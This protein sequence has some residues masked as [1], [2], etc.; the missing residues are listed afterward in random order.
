MLRF[1]NFLNVLQ[2][3]LWFILLAG[4]V[5]MFYVKYR[6]YTVSSSIS[7]LDKKIESLQSDK[8]LLT[9]ELTYLT[10]TERL[11]SLIDKNPKV[12]N[13]KDV[14]EVSQLKTKDQL[15]SISLAKVMNNVYENKKIAKNRTINDLIE[16]EL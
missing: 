7:Y 14:I 9:I 16:S 10:S 13:N 8:N 1:R 11:L 2:D 4:I 5:S 6:M 15:I 3:I 12:L